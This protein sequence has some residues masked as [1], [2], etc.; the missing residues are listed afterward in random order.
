MSQGKSAYDKRTTHY[1]TPVIE[2]LAKYDPQ[3]QPPESP[4]KAPEPKRLGPHK[5]GNEVEE[6]IERLAKYE[7][8]PPGSPEAKQPAERKITS[9]TLNPKE[10]EVISRLMIKPKRYGPPGSLTNR[11]QLGFNRY[12]YI[13][14]ED[15]SYHT[16]TSP[17][18]VVSSVQMQEIIGRLQ[19]PYG[20]D[21]PKYSRESSSRTIS[22]REI[23]SADVDGAFQRLQ[24]V[25]K[26]P[27]GSLGSKV[28]LGY[29]RY[30]F[31]PP[32]RWKKNHENSEKVTEIIQRLSQ[33]DVM[34]QPPNSRG[35]EKLLAKG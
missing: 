26:E 4:F 11:R 35:H 1:V 31:G 25:T 32:I 15:D 34:R 27:P 9:L 23:T 28:D 24:T 8:G 16:L 22:K 18:K 6:I 3:R 10:Q 12:D 14:E 30:D 7:K 13:L 33:F 5:S 20:S 2:R 21:K 17:S 19:T 29:G